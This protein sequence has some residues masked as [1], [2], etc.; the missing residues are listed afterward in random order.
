V[1]QS[2]EGKNVSTDVEDIVEMRRQ[3]TTGEDT[4]D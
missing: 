3:T 2:P 1:K 4:A